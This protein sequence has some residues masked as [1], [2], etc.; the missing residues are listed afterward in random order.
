MSEGNGKES[1]RK[2]HTKVME[3]A[4]SALYHLL[5]KHL[6]REIM[7][8]RLADDFTDRWYAAASIGRVD[9]IGGVE[10]Q[11]ACHEWI[12]HNL[13]KTATQAIMDTSRKW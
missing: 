6:T 13:E 10:W 5:L 3:Q 11:R 12:R 8:H 2:E 1:L 7:A 9:G 4:K